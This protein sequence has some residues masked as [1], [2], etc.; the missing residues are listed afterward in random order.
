MVSTRHP[1]SPHFLSTIEFPQT[2]YLFQFTNE[3]WR[4]LTSR[5]TPWASPTWSPRWW[6]CSNTSFLWSWGVPTSRRKS[7]A[8]TSG[9]E[10]RVVRPDTDNRYKFNRHGLNLKRDLELYL[11]Q[12]NLVVRLG[13]WHILSSI[14][15]C[16]WSGN[17]FLEAQKLPHNTLICNNYLS[18]PY[19]RNK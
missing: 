11:L 6:C 16:T 17:Q 15:A 5:A 13:Y 2:R 12:S 3:N 4:E 19:K 10:T 18:S 1:D 9:S 8:Q 7:A 14:W